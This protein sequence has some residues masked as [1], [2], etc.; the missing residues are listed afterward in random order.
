MYNASISR[1]I[2]TVQ[3][4]P[5]QCPVPSLL[6][7]SPASPRS[8]WRHPAATSTLHRRYTRALRRFNSSGKLWSLHRHCLCFSSRSISEGN[9]SCCAGRSDSRSGCGG[10]ASVRA[11]A[12]SE[13][14]W[15]LLRPAFCVSKCCWAL[16]LWELFLARRGGW[17]DWVSG[18]DQ[19]LWMIR[20]RGG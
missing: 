17:I 5:P 20:K 9:S 11:Y 18:V 14:T 15:S 16:C 6:T 4:T 3:H 19:M 10:D 8:K 2:Y 7:S 13:Y 12:P 1:Y